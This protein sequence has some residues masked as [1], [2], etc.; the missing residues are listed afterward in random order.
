MITLYRRWVVI[1]TLLGV[2]PSNR[3]ARLALLALG[4][5]YTH[6]E[7]MKMGWQTLA[8]CMALSLVGCSAVWGHTP[9]PTISPVSSDIK[10]LGSSRWKVRHAAEKALLLRAAVALPEVNA[11]L[12]HS[13]NPE[14][15][16]RLRRVGLQLYL[17]QNLP[18]GGRRPFLGIRFLV[19]SHVPE[20]HRLSAVYVSRVLTG[21]PAGRVLRQGDLIVGVNG[22]YF[23]PGMTNEDFVRLM[24]VFQAESRIELRV[25]RGDR[26]LNIHVRLIAAPADDL[27]LVAWMNHRSW[28]IGQYF[29]YLQH[30]KSLSGRRR[31]HDSDSPIVFFSRDKKPKS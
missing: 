7:A 25:L 12:A 24:S 23:G 8:I 13:V 10:R 27:R 5:E 19:L 29:K 20:M 30:L 3:R 16:L 28:L 9:T 15:A 17:E 2:C 14:V 4:H 6:D 1:W 18:E 26:W 11:A 22:H 31:P 21:L